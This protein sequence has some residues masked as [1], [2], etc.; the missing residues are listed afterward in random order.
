[1]TVLLGGGGESERWLS[2]GSRALGCAMKIETLSL[3]PCLL[4]ASWLSRDEQLSLPHAPA[5]MICLTSDPKQW[6]QMTLD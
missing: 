6:I 2:G 4:P 3:N 1:M 5:A